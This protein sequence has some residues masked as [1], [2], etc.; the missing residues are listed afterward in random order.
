MNDVL[1]SLRSHARIVHRLVRAGDRSSIDRLRKLR[2]LRT[3]TDGDLADTVQRRHILTA[4]ARELGFT[5]WSH[6]CAVVD[7]EETG[8]FGTL[9]YPH[10]LEAHWNIWSASYD[11]ARGIRA[12]HGG[13]LLTYKRHFFIVDE[14]FVRSL[15]LDPDDPDWRKIGRDWAQ[16]ADTVA[17]RRLYGKL[18]AT[19]MPTLEAVPN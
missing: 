18:I 16:P 8:D 12:E 13:F 10:G 3:L 7:R 4:M 1:D 14:H 6:L 5:G 2:E 11:E 17:R 15:G 9:L 19:R